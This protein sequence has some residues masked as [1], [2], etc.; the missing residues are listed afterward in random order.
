MIVLLFQIALAL[1]DW[2]RMWQWRSII[3]GLL[4]VTIIGLVIA[5]SCRFFEQQP[6]HHKIP[7]TTAWLY[8]L[9]ERDANLDANWWT[10]SKGLVI[11]LGV[12][13]VLMSFGVDLL[14]LPPTATIFLSLDSMA[15]T[16]GIV[17]FNVLRWVLGYHRPNKPK[18]M[19]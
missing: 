11:G 3:L 19:R 18:G 14:D 5:G 15:I 17:G 8:L 2:D 9:N 12:L 13:M 6:Q 1:A 16:L 7:E 4:M 10:W